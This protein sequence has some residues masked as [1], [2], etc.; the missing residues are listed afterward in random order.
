[1]VRP[2]RRWLPL[3]FGGLLA[4][5]VSACASISVKPGQE[6]EATARPEKIEVETFSV[7][8]AEFNVDRDGGELKVF[9]KNLQNILQAAQVA[10]L[11]T[12]L[13]NAAPVRHAPW[14]QQHAWLIRGQFILVNQG[15]RLLRTAIGFGAGGTK[16]ETRVQV[17]D[18]DQPGRPAFLSF[19][20]TGGSNAEPGAVTAVATDPLTIVVEA[21]LGGASG[22]SHGLTEDTK[23]TAREITAVLSDYMYR[24]Q[25]I[26][27]EKWIEPKEAHDDAVTQ[28]P[29]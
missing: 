2:I 4:V 18:L 22:F 19:T 8:H 29:N 7:A 11:S 20:T 23:R 10:D 9:K 12:R 21:T 26:P 5:L 15:S 6:N 14:F 25:W 1:M 3:F 27:K 17:Y 13:I 16:L 28:L 24:R